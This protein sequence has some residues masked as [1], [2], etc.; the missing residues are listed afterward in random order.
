MLYNIPYIYSSFLH[1]YIE[2]ID[3][4]RRDGADIPIS[5]NKSNGSELLNTDVI[6]P[7]RT[8]SLFYYTL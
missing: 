5:L 6:K 3:S 8:N 4:I 1:Y 7:F 2:S